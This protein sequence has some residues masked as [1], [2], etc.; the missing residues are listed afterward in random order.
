MLVRTPYFV[1]AYAT[2]GFTANV[3]GFQKP[4]IFQQASEYSQQFICCHCHLNHQNKETC[5]LK[6]SSS[7]LE[8][9]YACI[10]LAPSKNSLAHP[11]LPTQPLP[12]PL[13]IAIPITDPSIPA[14]PP[15]NPSTPAAGASLP[16]GVVSDLNTSSH[17][18]LT[19]P[20]TREMERKFNI[21]IYGL[22]ESPAC[23]TPRTRR[24]MDDM[25]SWSTLVHQSIAPCIGPSHCTIHFSPHSAHDQTL[26]AQSGY[27]CQ[28]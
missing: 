28:V 9:A 15:T 10:S 18:S 8:A 26:I 2:L 21:V 16:T 1:K 14:I 7:K 11:L 13:A 19:T 4:Y 3:L 24:E 23:G 27:F 17:K 22:E 25:A 20:S 6:F 5:F 12:L